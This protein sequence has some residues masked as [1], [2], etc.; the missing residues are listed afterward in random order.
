MRNWAAG[1]LGALALGMAWVACPIDCE[2]GSQ[3]PETGCIVAIDG[4]GQFKSVQEAVNAAPQTCSALLPWTI[5]VRPGTYRELVYVQ[6]EKHFVR[7]VGDDPL[8]TTIA[9]DLHASLLG[10]DGKPI[11]TFHTP[12]VW[13]D[14]DD[15]VVENLTLSNGSGNVGQALALRVDGDRVSFRNCRFLGWQDTILA[16]RGRQYF[17]ACTIKGAVDFIFGGATAYF[18]R[19]TI[20]CL[21]NG[22]ITAASTPATVTFGFVFSSCRIEGVQG[23]QTYLG[24]PWRPYANV[25]F[26]YTQMA[27]VVRPAG[28]HN[29]NQ[30]EREKTARYTEFG[31]T[32]PGAPESPRVPWSRTLT[33][34]EAGDVTLKRVLGGADGW[35]PGLPD[36]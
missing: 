15:F 12:T 4:S 8:T 19:C 16:N 20:E 25:I 31:S 27:S 34:A 26:L 29:W 33:K 11:G 21:G 36:S 2:G 13:I 23:A 24:R 6:R 1:G 18:D 3:L 30:P 17:Y 14:A 32:G 28:W 22:Y 5:H 35:N 7:L 9:F 10:K